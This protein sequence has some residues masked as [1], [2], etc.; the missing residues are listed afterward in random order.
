[1]AGQGPSVGGP[2]CEDPIDR[3]P[4]NLQG[5]GD[6][7]GRRPPHIREKRYVG[8]EKSHDSRRYFGD[9]ARAIGD[10]AFDPAEDAVDRAGV[11]PHDL[12][13]L[14]AICSAQQ[15]MRMS[16]RRSDFILAL[17]GVAAM[18]AI[19]AS[20]SA[21][22][23][24]FDPPPLRHFLEENGWVP[25]P[26]P[27][28][29]MGPGSVIKVTVKGA[30]VVMQWLGDLRRCGITDREFR[31][32]R[33]KYPAIGIGKSFE[34]KASVPAGFIAKLE[35]TAD[36]EK[37]GGAII[38]IEDSGGDGVDFDALANWIAKSGAARRLSQVCYAFLVQDDVYLVSEAFRISKASYGLVD[39]DGVKLAVTGGA[40]GEMGS[41]SSGTLSVIDDLYFGVR[42]LKQLGPNVFEP[43]LGLRTVP[44]ADNLLR[45]MEP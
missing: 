4:A 1:V 39:K 34:T 7:T 23:P 12:R 20:F 6:A 17:G 2:L 29:R 9:C 36:F 16:M 43:G 26:L 15:A 19:A 22:Q 42:R 8:A 25:L 3:R 37:A 28:K 21:A 41:R 32:V 40:F 18:V 5:F 30:S 33:G 45:L 24:T 31:Y 13:L 44:E 10:F 11:N 14:I 35:G 27:D 38:Q